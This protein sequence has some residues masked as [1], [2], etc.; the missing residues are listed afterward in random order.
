M[1]HMKLMESP[2]FE[3]R[4]LSSQCCC[5]DN[6]PYYSEAFLKYPM[7]IVYKEPRSITLVVSTRNLRTSYWQ[8]F[9]LL[10]CLIQIGL[11]GRSYCSH[12]RPVWGKAGWE[13]RL[14]IVL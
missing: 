9:W 12:V 1:A 3:I 11:W 6:Y 2:N 13:M 10:H 7:P 14:T 4:G 5:L 8:L